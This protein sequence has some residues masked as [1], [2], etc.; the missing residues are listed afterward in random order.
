MQPVYFCVHRNRQSNNMNTKPFLFYTFLFN[1]VL[2]GLF[3][4]VTKCTYFTGLP[5]R[6][7]G[8][9]SSG[10]LF[11]RSYSIIG[12]LACFIKKTSQLCKVDWTIVQKRQDQYIVFFVHFLVSNGNIKMKRPRLWSI[13]KCSYGKKMNIGWCG[14][15]EGV[16]PPPPISFSYFKTTS[17]A[18]SKRKWQ[19]FPW[20]RLF[21]S[22]VASF[23][24]KS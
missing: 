9:S 19:S 8:P 5:I 17:K 6:W 21:I 22:S 24:F 18:T 12:Q 1:P 13:N 10:F 2:K 14:W 7:S 3:H 20:S 11:V 16:T 4:T 23:L 15:G